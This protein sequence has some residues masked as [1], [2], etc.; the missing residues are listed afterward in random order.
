MRL[1]TDSL[2]DLPSTTSFATSSPVF[3][4][5]LAMVLPLAFKNGRIMPLN[6]P[7]SILPSPCHF[8]LRKEIKRPYWVVVTMVSGTAAIQPKHCSSFWKKISF[9]I[10]ITVVIVLY[11]MCTSYCFWRNSRH[12]C[13]RRGDCCDQHT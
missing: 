1:L 4:A 2:N 8:I 9:P 13:I 10:I 3:I 7:L 11:I 12:S 6:K 5:S